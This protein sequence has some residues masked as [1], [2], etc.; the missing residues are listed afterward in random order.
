[1]LKVVQYRFQFNFIILL[2][3][4]AASSTTSVST[5]SFVHYFCLHAQ[6]RPLLLSHRSCESTRTL[7]KS[8]MNI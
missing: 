5:R 6:L 4:R 7:R 2:S 8:A 1:M 3:P